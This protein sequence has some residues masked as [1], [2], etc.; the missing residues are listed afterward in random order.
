[1]TTLE[2]LKTI[3]RDK[4]CNQIHCFGENLFTNF[5]TLCP[6][7]ENCN[8]GKSDQEIVEKAEERLNSFFGQ[9]K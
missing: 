6:L 3:V 7:F 5:G 8:K 4:N 2:I 1:M 9:S